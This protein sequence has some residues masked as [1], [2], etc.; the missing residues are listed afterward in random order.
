MREEYEE[1]FKRMEKEMEASKQKLEGLEAL[2]KEMTSP[3]N[4]N[5]FDPED[6]SAV[7]GQHAKRAAELEGL[8]TDYT[9]R[10]NYYETALLGMKDNLET[11]RKVLAEVDTAH[12]VFEDNPELRE[13]FV[14]KQALLTKMYKE[15]C[16]LLSH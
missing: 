7:Q 16:T 14:N 5:V 3:D 10:R 4:K 9:K 15:T 2:L 1:M 8:E 13:F 11:R 6:I 12:K